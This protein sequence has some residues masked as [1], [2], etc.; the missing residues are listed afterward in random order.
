MTQTRKSFIAAL[1]MIIVTILSLFG[2]GA[3]SSNVTPISAASTPIALQPNQATISPTHSAPRFPAP[4]LTP[5]PPQQLPA[6]YV[7]GPFLKRAD[8]QAPVWLK[9]VNVEEF[10]QRNP[11]TLSDLYSTQGLSLIIRDKWGINLLRVAIDPEMVEATSRELDALV[12]FANENQMY[13][14][15]TPF[16]SAI[17]PAR[18]ERRL[19]IPDDLVTVAMGNLADKFRDRT[20]VLYGLWNE[21]HPED[22]VSGIGYAKEWQLWMEAGMKVAQAIRS[23]NPKA[24]LV[25]PGGTKWGRDLTFYKD[26]PFPFE[27]IIYDAHDYS[28]A[29][30]YHYRREMWTW[31]IG[32]Y[33]IL[34]GEF[35][36]NPINPF[37]PASLD[38]M[39]DTIRIVNQ[40]PSMVHYAVYALTD[41]GAWGIFTR[42]LSRMPKGTLLLD[43]LAKYPPTRFR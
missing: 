11:H 5:T 16:A 37:D 41:D 8:T 28:A 4:S 26:H 6:L 30:D 42:G 21:P 40:N 29:P 2:L 17:N 34:I 1:G 9:G 14:I 38:Y 24:I 33:P 13:V 3:F 36:G 25:V 27:N 39:R 12:T 10:R 19:P 18:N 15:L 7:D 23:K 20:N 32:K 43:D 35:G 31:A 22:S